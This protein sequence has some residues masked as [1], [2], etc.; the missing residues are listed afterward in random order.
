MKLKF[1][2][3]YGNLLGFKCHGLQAKD[4][5]NVYALGATNL[6]SGIYDI[7]MIMVDFSPGKV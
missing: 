3:K 2:S 5:V 7:H 1:F 4:T 6:G